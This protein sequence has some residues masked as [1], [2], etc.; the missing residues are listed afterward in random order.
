MRLKFLI[1]AIT[2]I[3]LLI[4]NNSFG[5]A[6][7]DFVS[8]NPNTRNATLRL[9]ETHTFQKII[10]EGDA[11]TGGATYQSNVDFT[12]Y[13]PIKGS[14]INGYLSINNE[15]SNG[16]V[17]MLDINYN[18][19]SKLWNVT[20]SEYVD[21]SSFGRTSRNC[22]GGVTPWG[23][24]ITSE[25]VS[26]S[27]SD[28][29]NDG[30]RDYGWQVELDPVSKQ[31]ID[32]R[33]AL[34]NF[35][36]EN[37]VVHNNWRTVYQ[38]AD[39]DYGYL[40]K[41]VADLPA[42]LSSGKLY[43]YKGSKTGGPGQ[44]ILIPN[45]TKT[46]RNNTRTYAQNVGATWFNG[47]EDVEIGP[48]GLVY[49]TVKSEDRIYYFEDS[50]PVSGTTVSFM[51]KFA[52]DRNYTISTVNGN[53][54]HNWGYGNDNLAFDNEGNLWVLQ[55]GQSS[56]IW[57]V[58]KG[59]TEA[60][61][62]VEVFAT[63]PTNCEP[64]GIT[65]SPD[66]RFIFLSIQHPNG[67]TWQTDAAGDDIRFNQDATLVIARKEFLG[68]ECLG[69]C[70]DCNDN[71]QNFAETGTDCG[72][73]CE[74]CPTCNDRIQNDNETGIDCGGS[75]C[76]S[77]PSLNITKTNPTCNGTDNGSAIAQVTGGAGTI[78]YLWSTGDT[79]DRV[80]N[81]LPG[82]YS[83]KIAD[84]NGNQA[85]SSFIISEPSQLNVTGSANLPTAYNANN[86][87]IS[88]NVSGGQSP[89]TYLWSN[90]RTTKNINNLS[91]GIYSVG[92]T[93]A[94]GCTMFKAFNAQLLSC[95]N[96]E[97]SVYSQNI[98]CANNANGLATALVAGGTAPFSYSW[99]NN[100][101]AKKIENLAP[102]NYSVTVT[103]DNG[104]SA[105]NSTT[106]TAPSNPLT[107]SF[108]EIN[109]DA[110]DANSGSVIASVSGGATPYKYEWSN[111]FTSSAIANLSKGA[112]SLK[113]TDDRGCT[114]QM[115]AQVNEYVCPTINATITTSD[116]TCYGLNNGSASISLSGGTS[117]YSAS[118]SNGNNGAAS[119]N[120]SVGKHGVTVTD[121][122]GCPAYFDFEITEPS[123][124]ITQL[125]TTHPSD[126]LNNDGSASIAAS[127]GSAGY[128][129]E[130]ST[131]QTTQ[132]ISNLSNAA[133]SV[134]V[135][136][137][138]NCS[139]TS[140][141]NIQ[142]DTCSGLSVQLST[143]DL[144]CY[145]SGDGNITSNVTGAVQ[146]VNYVWS[147]GATTND[148]N[149]LSAGIYALTI[150]DGS[151]C[152]AFAEVE[153]R[154]PS[155]FIGID[156]S[157]K[158]VT[159]AGGN[160][161]EAIAVANGGTAPYTYNWSNGNSSTS[162]SNLSPGNY[163]LNVRDANSCSSNK[164]FTINDVDCSDV[165]VSLAAENTGCSG[166][167]NATIISSVRNAT[168]P[169]SYNWSNN[170][171]TPFLSNVSSTGNYSLTATDAKGC[172]AS[173]NINVS[174]NSSLQASDNVNNLNAYNA[175]NGSININVSGGNS[176]YDYYWG[177][178][179]NSASI[180]NLTA[181]TYDFLAADEYGC[182]IIETNS[183]S[184][185]NCDYRVLAAVE[186]TS[187]R[188]G[189]D[190]KIT[191]A[192]IGGS[193]PYDYDWTDIAQN[194]NIR[195][196]LSDNTYT[197]T[198]TDNR[199]CEV[200]VNAV[201]AEPN[202]SFSVNVSKTNET[203]YNAFN[204]TATATPSGGVQP[205]TYE[206]STG[207]GNATVNNLGAGNYSVKATDANGC[208]ANRNFN[209][210]GI[211]CNNLSINLSKTDIDC[212]DA[213]NGNASAAVTGGTS[214]Y[215]ISWVNGSIGNTTNNL[216]PATYASHVVDA[217]G[218]QANASI[219]ITQPEELELSSNKTN[220]TYFGSQNGTA[221]V[222]VN[223]GVTPYV[224]SWS[225]GATTS[226]IS[227]LAPGQ[228]TVNITD[229]NDCTLTERI[230]IENVDCNN[231]NIA[232]IS[233]KNVTCRNDSDGEIE[234]QVGGGNPS[235]TYDWTNG[236][237]QSKITNLSP[238]NYSV[239]VTDSKG[240][241]KATTIVINN[242]GFLNANL[243]T[244]DISQG[245]VD[246][247]SASLTI[248]GGVGPRNISWSNGATT[249]SINNLAPG[250]Y[251]Y[252]VVDANG[253]S[254]NG[255]FTLCTPPFNVKELS[256]VDNS[257]VISWDG[258]QSDN[259]Y[260]YQYRNITTGS[261]WTTRSTT[262]T[263]V[264]LN[265]LPS[266][267]TFEFRV[268]G[269]CLPNNSLPLEFVTNGCNTCNGTNNLYHLNVQNTSAFI[270]W[271]L[272]PGA[273]YTI[274]YRKTGAS[275]WHS[276]DTKY[277][278]AIL[279]DLVPCS[280]YEWYIDTNCENGTVFNTNLKDNFAIL[281]KIIFL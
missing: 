267:N 99:S 151:G 33:W 204:G 116:I 229:A 79:T 73:S 72:G 96:F 202:A 94:N 86:G 233:K 159:T 168:A 42:D 243:S 241:T 264:L 249:Q 213:A 14:S 34:G 81:L 123:A 257:A 60:N 230:V 146:P 208:I 6:I 144:S 271:D 234:I 189:N 30:Y 80:D 106:I 105:T 191:L 194:T 31:V 161:G 141:F 84:S 268:S 13:V 142:P 156:L 57:V 103:D 209:I 222:N 89:Y 158:D 262:N 18:Q 170:A 140:N 68:S 252:T 251:S 56:H 250:D 48:D 164:T 114:L 28:I 112:Y 211:S 163:T 237:T 124:I 134:T 162:V 247:G 54:S 138:N 92:V 87:T 242:P 71:L 24:I 160:D 221:S 7:S 91:S 35:A 22:S 212:F 82:N 200:Q 193:F 171:T 172:T 5:Q 65:F 261:F 78:T 83:L 258:D 178:G 67:S 55:D 225:N 128:S 59:H 122:K 179:S 130:W 176:P 47:V 51:D 214:P 95:T 100:N 147:N 127:G 260:S 20:R 63:T 98:K 97:V 254:R 219:K 246:N 58:R 177:T 186:N 272:I 153:V 32:K 274:F 120:L 196:N 119:Q 240:C 121:S 90:N 244:T 155:K 12:G 226:S 107:V 27:F 223:G 44:W 278:F 255:S 270:N 280:G 232:N 10:Q 2:P 166:A 181:G 104:C 117:P 43:V 275:Q 207:L 118:W 227:N 52:G 167:A 64:T 129:Y 126:N 93:D 215:R 185:Y 253:C 263:F 248:S 173:R 29:N 239:T 192:T 220:I 41:F 238:G 74:N 139:T 110:I 149:N 37:A 206:W 25:E 199:N 256:V 23:T 4:N 17:A 45:T 174:N 53:V 273:T 217:V 38:G 182:T 231:I 154:R 188:N 245:G 69:S 135:T 26:S 21:F 259:N 101:S 157:L 50:D 8:V 276:Y 77:C 40:Y 175:N 277:T 150:T 125:T 46:E 1:L 265:N 66:G 61:P 102:G 224:Y 36:H 76:V 70:P 266:C 228:Y 184:N 205:I 15:A 195:S 133:Y 269:N 113:V 165:V 85:S 236:G 201:V 203:S 131:G 19:N 198:I 210:S 62:K 108:T 281:Q 3:L 88:I 235:F 187:C 148:I 132:S 183:V 137:Q 216:Q 169:I 145:N 279:Y 49:F 180:S 190:G 143:A 152:D 115:A 16:G 11:M 9:P 109:T 218:C 75:S 197:A 111:G 136:D 39:E